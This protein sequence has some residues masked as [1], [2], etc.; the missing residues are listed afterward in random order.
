MFW[1]A[2]VL[3]WYDQEVYIFWKVYVI[4]ENIPWLGLMI[5][6][7]YHKRGIPSKRKS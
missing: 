7:I 5:E 3:H 1:A 6:I 2:R 4:S